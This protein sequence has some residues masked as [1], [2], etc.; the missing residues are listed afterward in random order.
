MAALSSIAGLLLAFG[1]GFIATSPDTILTEIQA[2]GSFEHAFRI[3]LSPQGGVYVADIGRNQIIL[4]K[5]NE[6][7]PVSVG[8]YG[9]DATTFD[10]PT[11][12]ASDGL[13]VY[14]ADNGNHRIQRFDRNLNF[15]SSFTTRDSSAAATRFGYP[16][17]VSLSRL[18]DLFILDGENLR[19]LK[20]APM[21]RY[22]RSFGDIDDR[23][24]RLSRPLKVLVGP[25]DH[26]YVLEPGR[27]LEFDYFGHYLRSI[28]E[29]VLKDA[30]SFCLVDGGV[31]VVTGE[32]I[33]WFT[34]R[35][36]LAL[37]IR[38]RDL[39]ATTLT[40]PLEDVASWGNRIYLL[41]STRLH[42]FQIL[43]AGQ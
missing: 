10:R 27:L 26:A 4:Q 43:T 31:V 40:G 12:L 5:D 8:G 39:P 6:S 32:Q 3:A 33:Q 7:S 17:G 18:G 36:E 11:G 2:V 38:T 35:G 22:E 15:I 25:D 9:W 19:V 37:T 24:A 29:G 28:G 16:L 21:M 14:V 42:V 34:Q 1:G 23:R 41:T 30:R 13:N 20:F